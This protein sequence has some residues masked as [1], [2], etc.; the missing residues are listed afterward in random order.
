M[1]MKLMTKQLVA[2]STHTNTGHILPSC[3]SNCKHMDKKTWHITYCNICPSCVEAKSWCVVCGGRLI[4]LK[5]ANMDDVTGRLGIAV[6]H[7]RRD[8]IG[9]I[10]H[11]AEDPV[12]TGV[13]RH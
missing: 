6:S 7:D 1:V 9:Y 2:T 12:R 8:F 3:Y 10:C 11:L 5:A 4:A 13:A